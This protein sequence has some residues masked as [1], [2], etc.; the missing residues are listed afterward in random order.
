MIDKI[1]KDYAINNDYVPMCPYVSLWV[2][3][4]LCGSP[5]VGQP[6]L[7]DCAMSKHS[8]LVGFRPALRKSCV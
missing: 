7:L 4:G 8:T 1:K 6:H 3:V 5:R 2:A